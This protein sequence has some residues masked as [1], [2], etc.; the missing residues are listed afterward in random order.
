[1]NKFPQDRLLKL[2]FF[3]SKRLKDAAFEAGLK[4]D[5]RRYDFWYKTL[6]RLEFKSW[7]IRW[8]IPT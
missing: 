6:L 1:M 3:A 8:D 4:K 5:F 2:T 7:M